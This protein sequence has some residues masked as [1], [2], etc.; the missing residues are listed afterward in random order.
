MLPEAGM[1]EISLGYGISGVKVWNQV[2]IKGAKK[3]LG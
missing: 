2:S 1:G 3:E